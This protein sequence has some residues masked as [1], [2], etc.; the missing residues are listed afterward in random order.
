MGPGT[1]PRPNRVCRDGGREG[2]GAAWA[3]GGAGDGHHLPHLRRSR[4]ILLGVACE[5]SCFLCI[6]GDVLVPN[7]WSLK[8]WRALVAPPRQPGCPF[9]ALRG[10][11]WGP[12]EPSRGPTAGGARAAVSC[13]LLSHRAA[14]G[15]KC[16]FERRTSF[17]KVLHGGQGCAIRRRLSQDGWGALGRSVLQRREQ[18]FGSFT[19]RGNQA[20]PPQPCP[21]YR[22]QT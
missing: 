6:G 18:S 1:A 5:A 20:P 2:A 14:T 13:G 15:S 12:R 7:V 8:G 10:P 9:G 21:Q 22:S 17:Q 16:G 19:A 11:L 3:G 4:W